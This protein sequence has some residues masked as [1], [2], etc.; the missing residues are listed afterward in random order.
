MPLLRKEAEIFPDDLFD[1]A[2]VEPWRVAHVRSRHEKTLGRELLDRRIPYYMPQIEQTK[3]RT[4]R[5]FRS[6]LPLFSGYVFFRGDA[7]ARDVVRR[8]P[9]VINVLDVTDQDLLASELAQ[10][11]RLQ[12]AGASLRPYIEYAPGDVVRVR[13]GAFAGYSGVVVRTK[14]TMRLIVQVSALRQ[15]VAVEFDRE[16]VSPRR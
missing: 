7:A 13:E 14:G 16:H 2:I 11:R 6:F 4:G 9:A 5:T 1:R 12:L 10:I 3:R 15:Q 8:R